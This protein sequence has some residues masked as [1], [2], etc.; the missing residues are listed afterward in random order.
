MT[1]T[2][3][4]DG[5]DGARQYSYDVDDAYAYTH[6]DVNA[7]IVGWENRRSN[8]SKPHTILSGEVRCESGTLQLRQAQH[9]SGC[10]RQFR[11]EPLHPAD[12][13]LAAGHTL[14]AALQVFFAREERIWQAIRVSSAECV[15]YETA[16]WRPP[17]LQSCAQWAVVQPK[18]QV[19][20]QHRRHL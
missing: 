6:Y 17:Y 8:Q 19:G 3:A 10:V 18:E 15:V 2:T 12:H 9:P 5:G 14:G 16:L 7:R 1:S 20:H 4:I 13:P 11:L